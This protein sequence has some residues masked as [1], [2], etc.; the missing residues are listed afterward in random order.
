ML[1]QAHV[2][3]DR[4]ELVTPAQHKDRTLLT[5]FRL[6]NDSVAKDNYWHVLNCHLQAGKQ[7]GR[8]V[9]Q[10]LEGVSTAFKTAK[11]KRKG[12]LLI[13]FDMQWGHIC[14][15]TKL[16]LIQQRRIQKISN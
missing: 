14:Q 16:A 5:T 3:N 15:F 7:G 9:R 11:N 8:R 2:E 1:L 13:S 12:M 6:L 10:I 4:V